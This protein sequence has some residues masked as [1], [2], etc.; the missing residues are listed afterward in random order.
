MYAVVQIGSNQYRVSEGDVID[1]QL[2]GKERDE[3]VEI[4]KVLLF[5]DGK[6]VRI[7]RPYLDDV[8]VK[9]KVVNE[10]LGEKVVLFKFRRRKNS[11]WK[12]GH[13]QKL[14]GL[15]IEKISAS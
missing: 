12:K 6:Q 2:I 10:H 8:K 1:V 4:D 7:G 11:K 13:R 9:A 5:D 3:K 15:A 14:N